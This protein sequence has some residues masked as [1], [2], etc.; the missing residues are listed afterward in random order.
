MLGQGRILL[1]GKPR[2]VFDQISEL[3]GLG[4]APPQMRELAAR[5]DSQ[6][7]SY[8]WLTVEEAASDLGE[9][10]RG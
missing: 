3:R 8:A 10:I 1:E 4:L 7:N 2:E 6:G 9:V 5:F